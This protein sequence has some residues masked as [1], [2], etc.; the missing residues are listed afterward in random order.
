MK[1]ITI[2]IVLLYAS[3]INAQTINGNL[4]YHAGQQVILTGFN[5]Y[6]TTELAKDTINANG[7][8]T[9]NYPKEYK[10]MGVLNTKVD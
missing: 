2:I 3:L 1:K 8:F 7:N 9:L 4:K 10:G 5:Y 6:Q